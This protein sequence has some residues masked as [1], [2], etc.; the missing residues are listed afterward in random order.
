MSGYGTSPSLDRGAVRV[1]VCFRVTLP[2]W[3]FDTTR[4]AVEC[5]IEPCGCVE[6]LLR[7]HGNRADVLYL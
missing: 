2:T 5:A 4:P 1:D 6:G 7:I 3:R